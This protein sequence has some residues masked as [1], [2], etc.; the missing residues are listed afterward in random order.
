MPLR[1]CSSVLSSSV[2]CSSWLAT[3]L[4]EARWSLGLQRTT[5]SCQSSR[6][7]ERSGDASG[8]RE[9]MAPSFTQVEGKKAAWTG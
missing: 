2:S 6:M 7:N 8:E 1:S 4:A 5:P 9:W 3:S